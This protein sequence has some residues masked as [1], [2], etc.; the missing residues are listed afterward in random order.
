[1][2]SP[3]ATSWYKGDGIKD[4]VQL[5]KLVLCEYPKADPKRVYS[6]GVSRGG[7]GSYNLATH[8]PELIRAIACVSGIGGPKPIKHLKG[9]PCLI[10]HGGSD[11]VV[12][13]AQAEKAA[14]KLK[15]LGFEHKLK[16]FP[17]YGHNYH[18]EEYMNLTLDYFEQHSK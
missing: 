2:V 18:A 3:K 8:H 9:I 1:M 7:F 12:P 4:L 13:V 16:V 10:I 11:G 17:T 14:A 6:T 5:I 15:K